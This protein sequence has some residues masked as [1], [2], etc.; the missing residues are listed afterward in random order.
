MGLSLV[1]LSNIEA[2]EAHQNKF[3]ELKQAHHY[4]YD[5]RYSSAPRAR[6]MLMGI[7][8]GEGPSDSADWPVNGDPAEETSRFDFQTQRKENGS[9]KRWRSL[10]NEI[11]GTLDVALTEMFFWS[12]KDVNEL[13][14]RYGKLAETVHV[15]FCRGLNR[16]LIEFHGP[17][18]VIVVGIGKK[19][20]AL[21]PPTYD[22]ELLSEHPNEAGRTIIAEYTDG[23]RPWIFLKHWTG[24]R[25]SKPERARMREYVAA[26]NPKTQVLTLVKAGQET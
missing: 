6:F 14:Q 16:S 25:P 10:C 15:D 20:R 22:L 11:L 17:E 23:T 12:S 19:Y 13:E 26:I 1:L 2:I 3:P 21:L 7:N 18:A 5:K 9:A 8:P 4:V 24:A